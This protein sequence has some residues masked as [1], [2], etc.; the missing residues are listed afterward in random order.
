[1]AIL[2]LLYGGALGS[3]FG[4]EPV[5]YSDLDKIHPRLEA[6]EKW[7][8]TGVGNGKNGFGWLNLPY[9]NLDRI[10]EYGK[11]LGTFDHIVQIGIGGSSLGNLM[12]VNALCHP[13]HNEKT[14][15]HRNSPS[16][17]VADNVDPIGN[18][19]IMDVIDL[20]RTAL[21]VVSKSGSTAET[22]ANFLYFYNKL[23]LTVGPLSAPGHVMVITD[24]KEGNLKSFADETKCRKLA[25]PT[26]VGGRY[27]VLSTVGLVSSY[28]LGIDIKGL[29]DGAAEIDRSIRSVRQMS[30]NPAWLIAALH[31]LH[32]SHGRNIDVLMPY[33]DRLESFS[34]WYA[35][36][37]AESLAKDGKGFTPVR[38]L[39]CID[40]HSQVQ[41]YTDGP[42][43]KLFTILNVEK[44]QDFEIPDAGKKSLAGLSYLEGKDM[45]KMLSYEAK[46]TA[47]SIFKAGKPVLWLQIPDI[48]PHTIGGLVFLFEYV[49]ALTGFLMGVNPFDQPG[50]EQGKRYTYGLMG[51]D[52]F[53]E[54]LDEAKNLFSVLEKRS[55]VL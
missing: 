2:K 25:V 43:D 32:Y 28:A 13:Y 49:T 20:S 35:Q 48:S 50:V 9:Q 34:E 23:E 15:D 39:G 47:A 12:L 38:A 24:E 22:M 8:R 45:S 11:W 42:D 27:S 4:G 10:E 16:F 33:S 40:Q 46:S 54:H 6:A 53:G 1:M 55:S 44:S 3:S 29:L 17:H 37:C 36:L 41:L 14:H 5:L 21:V 7:L 31:Y 51:R 18:L 30:S 19:A 26:D 52:G